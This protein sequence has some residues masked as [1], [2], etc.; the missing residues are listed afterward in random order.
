MLLRTLKEIPPA[1]RQERVLVPGQMEAEE[2]AE[3]LANGIPMHEEVV[4]WF[5]T[6]CSELSVTTL[7]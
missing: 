2:Q 3:R 4:E 5:G 6:I 7:L 1:P